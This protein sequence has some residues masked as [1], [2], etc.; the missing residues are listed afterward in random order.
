MQPGRL[1]AGKYL[2]ASELG[3]GGMGVVYRAED[4]RLRRP[5]ALKFLS[6]ALSADRERARRFLREARAAA[7]LDNPHV[8][9]VYE[10]GEDE[11]RAYIAMA[12]IDG[13]SLKDR[14]ARGCCRSARWSG[15]PPR[16]PKAWRTHT[17]G[18]SSTATSSPRTSCSPAGG[19]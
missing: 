3:R 5:V 16:S 12:L 8:C 6:D 14:I 4:V 2:I 11:G 18:G 15:W 9:T 10:A 13:C 7:A 1:V 17:A 19:R